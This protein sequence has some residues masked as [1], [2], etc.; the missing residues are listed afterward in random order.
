MKQL[1]GDGF[2][3]IRNMFPLNRLAL[4]LVS[5][6][7]NV[8]LAVFLDTVAIHA[9][10]HGRPPQATILHTQGY[11][12][13]GRGPQTSHSDCSRQV[14]APFFMHARK[15]ESR[16]HLFTANRA[17]CELTAGHYPTHTQWSGQR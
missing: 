12:I 7:P 4:L 15:V 16:I 11:P 17:G 6:S 13:T 8:R 10:R 14:P 3:F 5:L 9:L 1:E 2:I